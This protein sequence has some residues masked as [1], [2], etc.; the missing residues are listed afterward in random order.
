MDINPDVYLRLVKARNAVLPLEEVITKV[1]ET[2]LSTPIGVGATVWRLS[3]GEVFIA[4]QPSTM[5]LR[6]ATKSPTEEA[7][8]IS[9]DIVDAWIV[10]NP[11]GKPFK[12][13]V[14]DLSSRPVS[15]LRGTI[16]PQ[17]RILKW[18]NR[19]LF[20]VVILTGVISLYT[21]YFSLTGLSA[22]MLLARLGQFWGA[23]RKTSTLHLT[24]EQFEAVET[25]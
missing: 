15:G 14:S 21:D 5:T 3:T 6:F 1:S 23:Y 19:L 24:P 25:I 8:R 11:Q 22:G 10:A 9:D 20:C 18:L 7:T 16:Q 2:L 12:I 17:N 4:L 13:P